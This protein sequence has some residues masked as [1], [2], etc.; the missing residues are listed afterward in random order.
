[1]RKPFKNTAYIEVSKCERYSVGTGYSIGTGTGP[2]PAVWASGRAGWY[3]INPSDEYKPMHEYMCE[4]ITIYYEIMD[5][6]GS[7]TKKVAKSNEKKRRKLL[8]TPIEKVL[9]KVSSTRHL[10]FSLS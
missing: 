3:E 2:W 6:Y 10:D 8:Q 7:M 1:M 5:I 4:G 9:F